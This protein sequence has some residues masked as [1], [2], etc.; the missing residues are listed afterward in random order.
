MDINTN[1]KEF[2]VGDR[3]EGVYL[4]DS[5]TVR[6]FSSGRGSIMLA[7]LRDKTGT[8]GC[9]IWNYDGPLTP[10][11]VGKAVYA[12]GPVGEY[13]SALQATLDE[14]RL[15]TP[16]EEQ[17][18]IDRLVPTAPDT[19]D[20]LW[21]I[22]VAA[23]NGMKDHDYKGIC[24]HMMEKDKSLFRTIP[25]GKSVHH[26]FVR[27]LLMHTANMVKIAN[28]LK[29]I[30]GDFINQD[31]LMAGVILHD[32]G[33]LKEFDLSPL[34]L[35]TTY[36]TDGQLLGHL[37]LGTQAVAD[38]AREL[39]MPEE[40]SRLLQHLLLSHH[41]EPE[42]GAAVRPICAEAQLLS[43]ID[44]IDSRM[45]S[46]REQLDKMKV[47]EVTNILPTFGSRIYKHF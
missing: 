39:G 33:K 46:Y 4:L 10:E 5:F 17:G 15:A 44:L 32:I 25:A 14:L 31:L 6:P 27:G 47:G 30:Y 12:A 16:K 28:C 1:T 19:G 20:K 45:E 22:I 2:K 35:V 41:G 8:I 42:F 18:T 29:G 38:A 36:S 11:D 26:A 7:N 13:N 34:G 3:L 9:K 40:K 21:G 43:Y 37:I 23:M 24:Q